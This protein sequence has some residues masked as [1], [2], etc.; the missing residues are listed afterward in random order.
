MMR[1]LSLSQLCAA[2][3]VSLGLVA[4]DGAAS[5]RAFPQSVQ[6]DSALDRQRVIAAH[7]DSVLGV[8]A[9]AHE[10]A[11]SVADPAI[12]TVESRD[13]IAVLSPHKDGE[14]ELLGVVGDAQVRA[15]VVVK[16]SSSS[17]SFRSFCS[18]SLAAGS[19]AGGG[20][21]ARTAGTTNPSAAS[22]AVM[23]T[24]LPTRLT[25]RGSHGRGAR[26]PAR[27]VRE[28]PSLDGRRPARTRAGA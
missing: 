26:V 1:V 13:G 25:Q 15:K 7:A 5:L 21:S 18:C 19:R 9:F 3:A 8:T 20:S 28:R 23:P 24:N 27:R 2:I 22:A 4:Q 16:N 11:W 12:A 10:V 6:L 14:T 17:K